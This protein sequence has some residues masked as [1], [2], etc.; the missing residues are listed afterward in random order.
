MFFLR[1]NLVNPDVVPHKVTDHTSQ[2]DFTTDLTGG[3]RDA[4]EKETKI[5]R[6]NPAT[7]KL[8]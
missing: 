3:R 1:L 7:L 8:A 6:S 4:Y 5:L 2:A